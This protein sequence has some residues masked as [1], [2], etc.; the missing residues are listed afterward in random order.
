[1]LIT[2][3]LLFSVLGPV[4]VLSQTAGLEEVTEIPEEFEAAAGAPGP[5]GGR[6]GCLFAY[7]PDLTKCCKS[8][9]KV[10]QMVCIS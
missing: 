4:H 3:T 8:G 5:V 6:H 7:C 10:Y 9:E 1:M 2:L